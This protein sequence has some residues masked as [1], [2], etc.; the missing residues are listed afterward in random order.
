M[1][2]SKTQVIHEQPGY[3]VVGAVGANSLVM[4][5]VLEDLLVRG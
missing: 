1:W 4:N 3:L 5:L 2:I